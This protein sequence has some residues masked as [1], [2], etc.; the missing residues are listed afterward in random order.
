MKSDREVLSIV[1]RGRISGHLSGL[2]DFVQFYKRKRLDKGG[3]ELNGS[4]HIFKLV[5][6]PDKKTRATR[7]RLGMLVII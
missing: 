1:F 2:A 7:W 5:Y 6:F 3:V 4:L